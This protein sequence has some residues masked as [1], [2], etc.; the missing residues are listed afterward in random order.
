ML[1][2]YPELLSPTNSM[3]KLVRYVHFAGQEPNT[4]AVL[5]WANNLNLSQ[6]L[7]PDSRFMNGVAPCGSV[8]GCFNDDDYSASPNTVVM[9]Y[10]CLLSHLT[11]LLPSVELS[12]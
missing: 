7:V 12:Q 3:E 8:C 6:D 1:T 11:V 5:T 2:E 9:Q 10:R 4:C